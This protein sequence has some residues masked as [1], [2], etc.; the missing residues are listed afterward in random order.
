M[1]A[2]TATS[3][4]VRVAL[5]RLPLGRVLAGLGGG[6]GG[7]DLVHE[8]GLVCAQLATVG[9]VLLL[10]GRVPV[11]LDGVVRA[12]GQVLGYLGPSIAHAHVQVDEE[13]VL[14]VGPRRLL[15]VRIE[16]VVPALAT[17]FAQAAA[18][19]LGDERPAL[20]A[21]LAYQVDHLGVLLLGPRALDE[22]RVEDLLPALLALVLGARRRREVRAD[23]L[24]VLGRARIV[25]AEA[26]Q[27]VVLFLGPAAL[28]LGWTAVER[29][30]EMRLVV[31]VVAVVLVEAE[32]LVKIVLVVCAVVATHFTACARDVE[33][34]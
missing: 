22:V 34:L 13:R 16:V 31:D 8:T 9:L 23:L 29:V 21:V 28:D 32:A 19:V 15:D 7:R 14:V 5:D 2:S 20:G 25:L 26:A 3:F 33:P 24:P 1:L 10:H 27:Q 18:Q 12:A 11:V 6:D 17:L 4:S 30:E